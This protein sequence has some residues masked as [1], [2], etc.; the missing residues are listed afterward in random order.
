MKFGIVSLFPEM[1]DIFAKFGVVG[2]AIDRG[3]ISAQYWNPRD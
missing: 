3:L 1:F 2:R